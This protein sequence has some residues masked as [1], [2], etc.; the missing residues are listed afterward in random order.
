MMIWFG[1]FVVLSIGIM[2]AFLYV[3][4]RPRK[5]VSG[6]GAASTTPTAA[7]KPAQAPP[8]KGKPKSPT[9]A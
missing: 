3:S 2:G 9:K 6:A 4:T 8:A 1:G 7:A 5:R